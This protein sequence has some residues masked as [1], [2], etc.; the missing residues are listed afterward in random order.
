L[1]V[2]LRWMRILEQDTKTTAFSCGLGAVSEEDVA[3]RSTSDSLA[4]RFIVS[5][6]SDHATSG[7]AGVRISDEQFDEDIERDHF[8][9]QAAPELC[10]TVSSSGSVV[11]NP[12]ENLAP[13]HPTLG[14]DDYAL[15]VG[16]RVDV[17]GALHSEWTRRMS[18]GVTVA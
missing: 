1:R 10:G 3:I 17:N 15:G 6:Q 16:D 2:D 13:R 18:P 14:D 11:S 8:A 5:I 12:C 4:S 9:P 7:R